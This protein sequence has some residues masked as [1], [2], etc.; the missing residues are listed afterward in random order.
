M[1]KFVPAAIWLGILASL[2]FCVKYWF[3]H[4]VPISFVFCVEARFDKLPKDDDLLVEWL[5]TQPGVVPHTVYAQRIGEKGSL[6]EVYL[7]QSTS[8]SRHPP[9]PDLDAKCAELGY[10]RPDAA[11]RNCENRNRQN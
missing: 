3:E 8:V 1:R 11:F 6:L 10:E 4:H 7:I 9:F 2:F 5:K